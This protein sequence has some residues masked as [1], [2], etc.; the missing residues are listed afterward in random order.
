MNVKDFINLMAGKL[1]I[2]ED[3]LLNAIKSNSNINEETLNIE[4][5]DET[6]IQK[7]NKLLDVDS[8][9]IEFEQKLLNQSTKS[10]FKKLKENMGQLQILILIKSLNKSNNCDDIINA[11]LSVLNNKIDNINDILKYDLDQS[12]GGGNY[13]NKYIKYKIKYLKLN[14]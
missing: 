11:L 3:I 2:K 9:F 1:N 4:I 12:G 5:T 10:S 7:I 8:Q 14:I 6:K 13:Y